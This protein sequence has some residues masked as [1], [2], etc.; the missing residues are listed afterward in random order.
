MAGLSVLVKNRF[1]VGDTLEVY[2]PD[3]NAVLP[4]KNM[5]NEEGT[6]VDVAPGSGHRVRIP[7]EDRYK[8]AFI[9]RRL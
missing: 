6:A 1:A 5:Q 7:L 8:G 4:L 3:G 2:H 9:A